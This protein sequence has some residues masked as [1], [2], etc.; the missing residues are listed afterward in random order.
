M[1]FT[2]LNYYEVDTY[3]QLPVRGCAFRNIA[4]HKL[5]YLGMLRLTLQPFLMPFL[6]PNPM[7]LWTL[8]ALDAHTHSQ[9]PST[10]WKLPQLNFI[11]QKHNAKATSHKGMVE[12]S[13]SHMIKIYTVTE[14]PTEVQL[15]KWP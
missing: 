2:V 10:R 15:T 7:H 12:T 13:E 5:I 4:H 9:L 3:W 11:L 6:N 14:D 8:S 1:S